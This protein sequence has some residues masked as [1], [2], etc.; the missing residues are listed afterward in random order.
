MLEIHFHAVLGKMQPY[1]TAYHVR[2]KIRVLCH[3]AERMLILS[4]QLLIVS[5][6]CRNMLKDANSLI[7]CTVNDALVSATVPRSTRT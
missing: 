6:I 5:I 4:Q 7:N 1:L 3:M 2:Q